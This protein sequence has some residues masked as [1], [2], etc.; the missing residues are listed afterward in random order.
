GRTAAGETVLNTA[1]YPPDTVQAPGADPIFEIPNAFPFR[2]TTYIG[3]AWADRAAADTGRIA[4]AARPQVSLGQTVAKV[5]GGDEQIDPL[6][7]ALPRPLRVALAAVSTDPRDLMRLARLSCE[8][9][10]DAS[11]GTPTGLVYD[12]QGA[13]PLIHDK[14]LFDTVAN[15]PSLPAPY[16][17]IMALRPGVQGRS[18]IVGEVIRPD[19]HVFEYLRRNSY[20]PWGHYAANMADDA[21]RYAAGDLTWADVR[22]MRH[23]YYQRTYVRLAEDLGITAPR[24]RQGLSAE[25]LESLR[26]SILA[27]MA[28]L[29]DPGRLPFTA[30][31]WG[32]NYG[33]GYAPSGYRLH[34][35]HQQIHQQY[36]LIPTLVD[37]P[38]GASRIGAYAC[39]DMVQNFVDAYYQH[40]GRSFF[41]CYL[42]A[43][44]ANRR[45]DGRGDRPADLVVHENE[46]VVL[47]VP[48]AQT[49]QWELQLMTRSRTGN[50]LEAGP[51]LRDALDRALLKAMQ[52]LA[53]MGAAMITVIEYSKRFHHRQ[54]DQRLVYAFLPRLPESPGGFS[55]AQLRWINGHYPEDFARVCRDH[56]NRL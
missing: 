29:K 39:G 40:T 52:T 4:I 19:T 21:V 34:A 38:D 42:K 24:T 43:I 5:F 23:L 3:K 51:A 35:S 22:G 14:Q 55:E 16:K 45:M 25:P 53:A 15:N 2:G 33:A 6:F 47:F 50:I 12:A 1:N 30:T 36:A 7:A 13:R 26:R 54:S 31:L 56:L 41:E 8:W 44:A 11:S 18:E 27:A 20:I 10:F 9:V 17:C 48:K 46:H 37:T 28:Q 32:W 49:S